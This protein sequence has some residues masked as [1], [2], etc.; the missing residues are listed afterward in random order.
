MIAAYGHLYVDNL[1]IKTQ[2][3]TNFWM[4]LSITKNKQNKKTLIL[5]TAVFLISSGRID[6]YIFLVM[7]TI[8]SLCETSGRQENKG[9]HWC[10]SK[11]PYRLK[12]TN[13]RKKI[14]FPYSC[15][16]RIMSVGIKILRTALSLFGWNTWHAA[17][18]MMGLAPTWNKNTVLE[19]L[20]APELR[21]SKAT[22]RWYTRTEY[23]YV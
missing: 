21:L 23:V 15:V 11:P 10:I 13:Q 14:T 1:Y 20:P 17:L 12:T 2:V 4:V 22:G 19:H 16:D 3:N 18:T 7:I 9:P 6:M 5:A 8:P